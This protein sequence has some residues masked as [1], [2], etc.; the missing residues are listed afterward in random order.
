MEPA[1]KMRLGFGVPVAEKWEQTNPIFCCIVSSL[2]IT[3]KWT[4]PSSRAC[5]PEGAHLYICQIRAK[6][7]KRNNSV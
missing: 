4:L 1:F 7:T 2:E 5:Q 3:Q 6:L